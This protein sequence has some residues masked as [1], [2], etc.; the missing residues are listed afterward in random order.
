MLCQSLSELRAE[1]EINPLGLPH[2]RV[3]ECPQHAASILG[4]CDIAI[5][6]IDKGGKHSIADCGDVG[7][8]ID[9][10]INAE[11]VALIETLAGHGIMDAAS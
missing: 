11:T 10:E 6:G 7:A 4:E 5:A 3:K 8:I 9:G 2:G 1:S